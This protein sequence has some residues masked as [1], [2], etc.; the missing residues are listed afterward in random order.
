MSK[1]KILSK[2]RL[3]ME[4]RKKILQ[5]KESQQTE[6]KTALKVSAVAEDTLVMTHEAAPT[7]AESTSSDDIEHLLKKIKMEITFSD[8]STIN[9]EIVISGN[10][11]S[12]APTASNEKTLNALHPETQPEELKDLS[13]PEET[14]IP[15]VTVAVLAFIVCASLVTGI[16]HWYNAYY[17]PPDAVDPGHV[18]ADPVRTPDANL[19]QTREDETDAQ[20]H[21]TDIDP[22]PPETSRRYAIE[23][24]PE[25]L[26]LWDEHDNEDIVA[27]LTLGET[28]IPVVQSNDNAFYI[29]HDIN[30]NLSPLGWVFLDYQVDLY[31]GMEHNMVIYDPTGEFLRSV[32][33]EFAEYDFFLRNPMISLSTL[34]GELEWEIFSY[35]IAPSDFPFAIVDHPDDDIWG[36][37]VE[38]FT[39]ASLY[40]AMLDVTMYDQVLTIVVPTTVN[41]ELFYILQA[42]MLRQITS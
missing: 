24:L 37:T 26:L 6:K 22:D 17:L 29:T 28:E 23:P 9:K 4:A 5:Q 12:K 10:E 21:D 16:I 39:L 3:Q 33:Q 40:N 20:P 14:K 35:Y 19:E 27:I 41:P 15:W 34:F 38:Q 8:D 25:F 7:I 2:K 42:R 32:M 36:E 11:L 18:I 13:P 31:I 1:K 30:G